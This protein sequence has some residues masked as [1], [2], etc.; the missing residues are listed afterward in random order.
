MTAYSDGATH[1]NC[2]VRVADHERKLLWED[3]RDRPADMFL[4]L[5]SG[6]SPSEASTS[7]GVYFKG[8]GKPKADRLSRRSVAGFGSLWG[9]ANNI[10]DDQQ[11][12]EKIWDAYS[13]VSKPPARP[14]DCEERRRNIRLNIMFPDIRPKF[15]DVRLLETIEHAAKQQLP[16]DFDVVEVAHRLVA[17]CF[18]FE[19]IECHPAK[20]TGRYQCIGKTPIPY[21]TIAFLNQLP[22]SVLYKVTVSA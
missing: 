13:A 15:D 8:A 19:K 12:C 7:S 14:N 16:S 2:P 17:S 6:L 5:G 20:G 22:R 9:T 11:N 3:V 18:Y 10:I 4:S 1:H 21:R